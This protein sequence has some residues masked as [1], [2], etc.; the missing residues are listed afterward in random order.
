MAKANVTYANFTGGI[1]TESTPLNF[2]ENSAQTIDNLLVG[3][4]GSIKRRLGMDYE[5]GAVVTST[6]T[7][8]LTFDSHAVGAFRWDNVNNDASVSIGVI[9]MGNKL[10]FVDLFAASPS[11]TLLNSGAALALDSTTVGTN[12]SGNTP[13]QFAPAQGTLIIASEEMPNPHYLEYDGTADTFSVSEIN[14]KVRDIWGVDDGLRTDERPTTLSDTHKYN[15][16]NQGWPNYTVRDTSGN[17]RLPHVHFGSPYPSN[18]DIWYLGQVP[19]GSAFKFQ[20]GDIK[21]THF[22]NTRAA[23]GHFIIDAFARGASR[24]AEVAL[25]TESITGLPTDKDNG[26]V[27]AVSFY[28]GR[29]WYAGVNSSIT[30][31]DEASPDY[32]GYLFFSQ[33]LRSKQQLGQ[34][35]QEAD[36]TSEQDSALV[37]TD[38]GTVPIPD[39]SNILRLIPVGRSLVVFAENGVWEVSGSESGFTADDFQISQ[40]TNIGVASAG[41]I[42]NAEG[43]VFYWSKGGI[44]QLVTDKTSGRLEAQN[45][46]ESTIQSFYIEIP[47]VGKASATGIFDEASRQVRWLYNDS[48]SY[49]GVIKKNKYNRE[50]VLDLRLGAMFTNTFGELASNSPY[51]AG[52]LS[53]PNFTS[54]QV[55][56]S[57]VVDGDQVQVNGEDV[58]VTQSKRTRGVSSRLYL[59]I[60]PSATFGFTLAT[61]NNQSFLDW[62][63]A[64]STG[65]DANGQL[66]TGDKVFEDVMRNK[67]ITYLMAHFNRTE[68]G[69]QLDGN[70]DLQFSNPSSCNIQSRWA[71]SDSS[72]S[73]KYGTV[74]QA[75]RF[76]RNYVPSGPSDPFDYGQSVIT[77]KS[78]LRGRGM[79]VRFNIT[80]EAGKDLQ[81]LGW[82]IQV[83]GGQN[84]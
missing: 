11:A 73:G 72:N 80:T 8:S 32:T 78:K 58:V 64:D 71:F 31:S 27:S 70:G 25:G 42:V 7:T 20:S 83:N 24:E 44:Y 39:A 48:D 81:L 3:R 15:L 46:T 18:S 74:F 29:V 82:A 62:E 43:Q 77:T 34:C 67:Q 57:V 63:D 84:V 40:V 5:P 53:S 41:S 13:V 49:D 52:Y 23:Q 26:N 54:T 59:S 68:T 76:N 1:H 30:Q 28:A 33:T 9:Q 4:D 60:V 19:D 69:F 14:L 56:E 12:I 38:G 55:Q 61:F 16:F 79:A 21:K 45:I 22:G 51:V 10:W 6:G 36:P 50:L 66:E 65:V 35:Y 17:Q 2:P 47:S 37:A 75:Y